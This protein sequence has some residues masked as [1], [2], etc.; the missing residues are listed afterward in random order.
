VHRN[1]I[2]L[3]NSSDVVAEQLA[4]IAT[5]EKMPVGLNFGDRHGNATILDFDDDSQHQ[6]DD[7]I[8]DGEF[9]DHD[10]Q[11]DDDHTLGSIESILD[12]E[13]VDDNNEGSNDNEND[14]NENDDNHDENNNNHYSGHENRS[15]SDY[16]SDNDS[17]ENDTPPGIKNS[18]DE[19]GDSSNSDSE[20]GSGSDSESDHDQAERRSSR[21]KQGP[22]RYVAGPASRKFS[23]VLAQASVVFFQAV[24]QYQK[25][26]AAM[27]TKQ[28]SM[29]AGL[30]IF[31]DGGLDAVSSKIR[32]NLHG[33]GVIEPVKR[34]RV[35]H[36]IGMESLSY[37]VFLK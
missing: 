7:N 14:D 6:Q 24:S 15:D 8:S 17:I 37:L 5:N 12:E 13:E 27:S 1:S 20:S 22:E 29:K 9:S 36:H 16:H 23:S 4:A 28:Y 35:T 21:S 18:Y 10:D 25:I 34:E 32:D 19:V 26:E 33:R 3:A 30:K 2:T 31:V 11:L